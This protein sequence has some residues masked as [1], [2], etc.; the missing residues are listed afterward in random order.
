MN[1][2]FRKLRWLTQRGTKEAELR[3]EL[4]FHMEEE[5]EQ[6]IGE[7][8]QDE[9]AQW[10]ARRELGNLT[11]VQERTRAVWGWTFLEQLVQDLRYALRTM[12]HNRLFTALSLLSLALGIGAN[13]AIYSFMDSI[14][15]RALPVAN[16][17]S[18][19]LLN[20]HSKE[21]RGIRPNHVM[22]GMDGETWADGNGM[23]SG[24]FPFGAFELLQENKSIFSSLFTYCPSDKRTLTIK[25]QAE[26]AG[27][28][29]VSGDYFRGLEVPPA[30]GR[31]IFA[32]DDRVG[33]PLVVV[34]SMGLSE[35]R[36]PGA[37]NAVGQTI[38]ID[39][40]PFTVIG[41]TPPE[42]FGLDP[43][44]NPDFYLPMHTNLVLD[45]TV[46]WAFTPKTYH[47]A[48]HYW[49]EMMGRLRP[50]VSL[51]QAQ[52]AQAPAFHHWV[53]ATAAS[54]RELESL[55]E[56]T[57]KEAGGGLGTLRRR[58]SK[59]LYVLWTMVGLILAIACANTANLLLSRA[60]ARRREM[61]VRLSI[62]A[63][64]L[65]L[66]RQLL[67][68]S[69]LLA[70]VGG[71]LGVLLALW[72]VRILTFLLANGRQNFTLRA[73]LNWHVLVATFALS[74]LCGA[75]FGLAPA[76]QSTRADVMPALKGSRAA[77][78]SARV[79]LVLWH[80]TLSQGLLVSQIVFS[81]MMLVAAGLF[82]RTLS[83]LQSIQMG[84]DREN[85]L[86]FE[87]NARQSGHRDPEIL[88]FYSELRT[89]F[90]AIPGVRNATLSHASLLGA[91]RR[92]DIRVAG[93][94]APET[95]ILNTGPRFFSTMQ[96]PILLGREIDERD[97][98]GSPPV[99]VANERFTNIHFG[100]EN[101][102]GRRV[103]LGGPHPREMEIVGVAANAHYGRLKDD[104]QPVLYIP[105]NQGDPPVQ[106][107]VYALR[108][109]GDPL[110]YVKT[111]RE[112]VHQADA[113]I[114]VMKVMTQ[115]VEIDRS[116]NQEIIFARLCT[117]FAALALVIVS[118]GLYG[119][120]A[121]AAA[122]RTGEIGIRIALGAQRGAVVRMILR[123]VFLLAAV[124]L[125]IGLPAALGASRLV[126]SF[127]FGIKA[128]DPLALTS[129]VAILLGA[130]LLAGYMPARKA[131]RID[132][133]AA[134]RH[135]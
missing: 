40:L 117:G 52:A 110:S 75:V 100:K 134:L 51:A 95:R 38:L 116:M 108:T 26:V 76:I 7:G 122:R 68:E 127:L 29:Y 131:S 107:M 59:P 124:G 47:D 96:I 8:W 6:R 85:L 90:A 77:E 83:N 98:P 82:V 123:Q 3:Q 30:A 115:A 109:A 36:F 32:N 27:G 89:R 72:G 53:A 10:A 57:V 102:L 43:E 118:V 24:I 125:A 70:L 12:L 84:F 5:A 11:T 50:G 46:S 112:T 71:T 64:R 4:Q 16:P 135:E 35:R 62:G 19:A 99:V 39:N 91:G 69:V 128:N 41:V 133:I 121:Y 86:L 9:N 111:V 13:T 92:L 18:L 126:E 80:V 49:V 42:F 22:H 105:Y 129:A 31:L 106:Q 79:R 93:T 15:L 2:F 73:E 63:G 28:E 88:T 65:R 94:P 120:M 130:A 23:S 74:V 119:T 113:R 1:S 104:T 97:R 61:A 55:P 103:T 87:L 78:P 67:T 66:I 21:P 45:R 33:A 14:L 58:Y 101:P 48:N 20:W 81:L 44:A 132:P 25:G 34:I 114:P 17:E 60:A 37:A 54:E 56:L